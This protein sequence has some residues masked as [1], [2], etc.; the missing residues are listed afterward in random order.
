MSE[1]EKFLNDAASQS[2]GYNV[3]FQEVAGQTGIVSEMSVFNTGVVW[4]MG[5]IEKIDGLSI[6]IPEGNEHPPPHITIKAGSKPLGKLPIDPKDE[7]PL[8]YDVAR[9]PQ[10]TLKKIKKRLKDEKV[11][12]MYKARWDE[13]WNKRVGENNEVQKEK[14]KQAGMGDS[15]QKETSRQAQ[16]RMGCFDAETVSAYKGL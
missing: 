15:V 12:K 8:T 14:Q 3:G 2:V 5:F 6:C 9:I 4:N 11:Q 7:S 1:I 13:F 16:E 10:G